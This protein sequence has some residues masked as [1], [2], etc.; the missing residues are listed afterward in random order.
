MGCISSYPE[1]EVGNPCNGSLARSIFAVSNDL[2]K[3]SPRNESWMKD[4]SEDALVLGVDLA[5][6]F[7]GEEF[8]KTLDGKSAEDSLKLEG[9]LAP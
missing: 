6:Q 5:K 4:A 3:E 2:A 8:R 9:A 7:F 1:Q